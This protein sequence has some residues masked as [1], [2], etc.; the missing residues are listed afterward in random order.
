M[1]GK[2]G[3]WVRFQDWWRAC[4]RSVGVIDL[5]L[6]LSLGLVLVLTGAVVV[7]AAGS[8]APP[9]G[10]LAQSPLPTATATPTVAPTATPSTGFNYTVQ[11]GDTLYSI[12]RR[13]GTTV[14]AIVQANG[15]L[16]P[17]LIFAGQVLWIPSS[18][19]SPGQ[20]GQTIYIVQKGDT[21]YSIACRF[22]TT[23]QALA[24]LNGIPYP[25]TIYVGQKLVI[26]AGGVPP[27]SYRVH[28]VQPGETLWRI[29]LRYG[30]TPWAIA[31]LNGLRNIHLIY[32]GQRLLIP[33]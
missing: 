25:Y 32:A 27:T 18:G 31:S 28:I 19:V 30:T 16:N 23:Y 8:E 17:N 10:T 6:G 2:S 1:A 12:A 5:G 11:R 26:S 24:S 3:I 21:L 9:L 4:G 22:G 29:A 15:I 33:W 20:P 7:L 13:F 14:N